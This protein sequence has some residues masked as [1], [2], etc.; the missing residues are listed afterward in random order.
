MNLNRLLRCLDLPNLIFPSSLHGNRAGS[1]ALQRSLTDPGYRRGGGWIFH[2]LICP[3][4]LLVFAILLFPSLTCS[5][6]SS[7]PA[8]SPTQP[9]LGTNVR[10]LLSFL[11]ACETTTEW[12]REQQIPPPEGL[13]L[14]AGAAKGGCMQDSSSWGW[15]SVSIQT[16]F[17][18]LEHSISSPESVLLF[19]TTTLSGSL[20]SDTANLTHSLCKSFPGSKAFFLRSS[21]LMCLHP[22]C[23]ASQL[24]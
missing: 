20:G 3:T 16:H 24:M 2:L 6:H 12:H 11:S 13:I 1:A 17:S 5:S 8:P 23:L 19:M 7:L 15:H 18:Y 10:H 21:L 22:R 14:T 4:C 9:V